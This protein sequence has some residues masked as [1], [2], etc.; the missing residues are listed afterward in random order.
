MSEISLTLTL[1]SVI[2][3]FLSILFRDLDI[4]LKYLF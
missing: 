2:L 1:R 3:L 4:K